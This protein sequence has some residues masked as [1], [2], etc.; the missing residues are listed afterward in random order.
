MREKQ[1][2]SLRRYIRYGPGSN[3]P[4]NPN[5]ISSGANETLISTKSPSLIQEQPG[6][7]PS[8]YAH[9]RQR[10][11]RL[12]VEIPYKQNQKFHDKELL[13]EIKSV[14]ADDNEKLEAL[15]KRVSKGLYQIH[16]SGDDAVFISVTKLAESAGYWFPPFASLGPFVN[17]LEVNDITVGKI[18]TEKAD[19]TVHTINFIF[20]QQKEKA[21]DALRNDPALDKLLRPQKI[22]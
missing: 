8:S 2:K 18:E 1:R 11:R 15:A 13:A 12:G 5:G 17:T 9:R 7:S 4:S 20:L 14:E 21:I 10:L 3:S 16:K 6:I 19:S 22:S